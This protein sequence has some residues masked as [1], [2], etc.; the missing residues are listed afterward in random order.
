MRKILIIPFLLLFTVTVAFGL[1]NFGTTEIF[2]GSWFKT[3]QEWFS[4]WFSKGFNAKSP[5]AEV[6]QLFNNWKYVVMVLLS[7]STITTMLYAFGSFKKKKKINKKGNVTKINAL[8]IAI[9]LLTILVSTITLSYVLVTSGLLVFVT[10]F[11]VAIIPN[12]SEIISTPAYIDIEDNSQNLMEEISN[13]LSEIENMDSN[14]YIQPQ[15]IIKSGENEINISEDVTVEPIAPVEQLEESNIFEE[16]ISFEELVTEQEKEPEPLLDEPISF[17]ELVTEQ[18]KEPEVVEPFDFEKLLNNA[19]SHYQPYQPIPETKAV[20]FDELINQARSHYQ[21]YQPI[22]ET[23]AV[24]FDELINQAR[25]HYQP[26]QPIPEPVMPQVQ[27]QVQPQPEPVMPQVQQQVQPQ[28]EPVVPQVQ[29]Q[30]Q[31]QTIFIPSPEPIFVKQ[32]QPVIVQQSELV[33]MPVEPAPISITKPSK[34]DEVSKSTAERVELLRQIT[35]AP[36]YSEEELYYHPNPKQVVKNNRQPFI[37]KN[38]PVSQ[39]EQIKV[40]KP[41]S[42]QSAKPAP[43]IP[44]QQQSGMTDAQAYREEL[45]RKLLLKSN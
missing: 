25:S 37:K 29:Q 23:K 36:N 43:A 40:A 27:Q 14:N 21:P 16:P 11:L 9:Y 3:G 26:Y 7:L 44:K 10:L 24:P 4:V 1:F 22:P 15:P 8:A 30:V 41:V 42:Q 38:Q 18:E 35:A 12:K 31:P 45:K 20:P 32:Q 19:R 33:F 2:T 34:T 17:E 5:I 6:E 39:V 13:E 28:P